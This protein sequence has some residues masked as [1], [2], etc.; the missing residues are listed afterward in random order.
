MLYFTKL[1][2]P[3]MA[4]MDVQRETHDAKGDL[5]IPSEGPYVPELL[6]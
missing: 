6:V 2:L 5:A 3:W 4:P 1:Y